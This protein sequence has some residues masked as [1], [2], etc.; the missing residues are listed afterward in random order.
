METRSRSCSI[1]LLRKQHTR[2]E[3]VSCWDF[4]FS[5]QGPYYHS[6]IKKL[7][8]WLHTEINSISFTADI[9]DWN[10]SHRIRLIRGESEGVKTRE[11]AK[12]LWSAKILA[13]ASKMIINYSTLHKR[14]FR[15]IKNRGHE[16]NKNKNK[17]HS[18]IPAY[19]AGCED[20]VTNTFSVILSLLLIS[21]FLLLPLKPVETAADTSLKF[22]SLKDLEAW[23]KKKKKES[24]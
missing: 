16:C 2:S 21:G 17:Q 18:S 19:W 24:L 1:L 5:L 12:P 13:C 23:E 4:T 7:L 22:K 10:I 14:K 6:F 8:K 15:L 20:I 11:K 3:A 9:D